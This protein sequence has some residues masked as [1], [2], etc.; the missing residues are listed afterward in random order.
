MSDL[1]PAVTLQKVPVPPP[2]EAA[3]AVAA[4]PAA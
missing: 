4:D 1:T 2:K 3:P